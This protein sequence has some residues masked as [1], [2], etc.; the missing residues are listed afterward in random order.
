MRISVNLATR[1]YADLGPALKRLR[2]A[3]SVLVVLGIGFG[4]GLRAVHQKAEEA[5][6]TEARVQLQI[7]AINRERL[8]YDALMHQP[9]NAELLK[10]VN[11]LNQLFDEK[12]FS[13]TLAMEDLE[14]VLPGGVQVVSLEPSR[15]PK[16]GRITLK[17]RVIG[18]RDRADDLVQN[19]EHSRHFLL[20]HIV[21]ESSESTGGPNER[22]EPVSASNRFNFELLADYNSAAPVEGKAEKKNEK[23]QAA[24]ERTGQSTPPLHAIHPLPSA[25]GQQPGQ[26]PNT[27]NAWFRPGGNAKPTPKPSAPSNA[28]PSAKPHAGGPR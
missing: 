8:G 21:S 24:R 15:D 1:P 25:H 14:T 27:G 3:M 20:P 17:L 13:W 28:K 4:L 16:T 26:P 18:A 23:P 19:L 11:T 5:R 6:A 22:L 12:T 7:D 2:I 10:Q 9:V